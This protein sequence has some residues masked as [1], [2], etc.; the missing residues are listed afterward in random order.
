M[1]MEGADK[2]GLGWGTIVGNNSKKVD[3][4]TTVD[5]GMG[6]DERKGEKGHKND[7][8]NMKKLRGC[9]KWPIGGE[10]TENDG[11]AWDKEVGDYTRRGGRTAENQQM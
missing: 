1:L 8:S 10:R 2:M 11:P 7:Q 3:R 5:D 4:P 6:E 9:K